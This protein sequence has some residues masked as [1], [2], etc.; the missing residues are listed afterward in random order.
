[1]TTEDDFLDLVK[2][3]PAGGTSEDYERLIRKRCDTMHKLNLDQSQLDRM[4]KA[5][6]NPHDVFGQDEFTGL[7]DKIEEE[8]E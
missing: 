2:H 1:M 3:T 6:Q 4:T 7:A 5:M 8:G